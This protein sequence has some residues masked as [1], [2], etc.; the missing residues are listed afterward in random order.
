[1]KNLLVVGGIMAICASYAQESEKL[2]AFDRVTVSPHINVVLMRGPQEGIRW[3]LENIDERKIN[4]EVVDGSLRL[5][6]D[7]ARILPPQHT[8]REN[9]NRGKRSIYEDVSVTAH[10][11]YR[12]LNR[13]EIRGA[14]TVNVDT[15]PASS[16]LKIVLYGEAT[17]SIGHVDT[18]KL[19]L[20]SFGE[21][22]VRILSG[23]AHH[24]VYRMFGE[25][26]IDALGVQSRTA[27]TRFYG[28]GK[29]RLTATEEVR[30]NSFGEPR[31]VLDGNPLLHRCIVVGE[32]DIT[33]Q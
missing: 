26:K 14:Q 11:T 24:Q 30:L 33:R 17:L 20:S 13:L 8:F 1:M 2:P 21:N 22:T 9:G 7:D 29:L 31:L 28:E 27:F 18:E 3:E 5:Y 15:I 6:L 10:V 4:A 23:R 32:T 12:E 19:K 25:N 16:K